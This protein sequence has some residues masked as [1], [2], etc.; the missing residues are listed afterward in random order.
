MC[1][2]LSG[3]WSG[4]GLRECITWL[5]TVDAEETKCFTWDL[6]SISRMWDERGAI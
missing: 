5:S 2:T 3:L 4:L 1:G 6:S